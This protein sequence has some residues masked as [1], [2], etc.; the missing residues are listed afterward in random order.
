[1]WMWEENW[2]QF[3][4]FWEVQAG[5]SNSLKEMGPQRSSSSAATSEWVFWTNL[6]ISLDLRFLSHSG[7][8]YSPHSLVLWFFTQPNSL[9]SPFRNS[10]C[11][12]RATG[13][14]EILLFPDAHLF[15]SCPIWPGSFWGS[16]LDLLQTQQLLCVYVSLFKMTDS[17]GSSPG[18]SAQKCWLR[19]INAPEVTRPFAHVRP[20]G[21][22][23]NTC[24]WNKIF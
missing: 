16:C 1:M 7:S 5:K 12:F 10:K 24:V 3:N 9:Y 20:R 15:L 11:P 13:P 8:L 19:Q 17:P 18:A 22:S 6:S 21:A 23:I 14:C 2:G 4:H